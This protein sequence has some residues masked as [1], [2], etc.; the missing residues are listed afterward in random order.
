ML[1]YAA[2]T[3]TV[4]LTEKILESVKIRNL[5]NILGKTLNHVMRSRQREMLYTKDLFDHES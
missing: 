5:K 3:T 1:P 4:M 2:V